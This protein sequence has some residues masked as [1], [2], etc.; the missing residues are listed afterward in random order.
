[1]PSPDPRATLADLQGNLVRALTGNGTSPNGFAAERLRSAAESLAAKRIRAAARA[2]PALA[3]ALGKNFAERFSAYAARTPLPRHG[4]ALADGF[5]LARELAAAGEL[6]GSV[7]W[8]I[9][10]VQLRYKLRGKD[11]LPRRGPALLCTLLRSPRRLILAVRWPWLGESWLSI[12][13]W[14]S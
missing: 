6:P 12:P 2:W 5:A 8:E 4:G 7:R 11:L 1:M 3:R 10:A 13:L 14:P 9:M